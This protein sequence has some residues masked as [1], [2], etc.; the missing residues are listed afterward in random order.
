MS[1]Y[2]QLFWQSCPEPFLWKVSGEPGTRS[3]AYSWGCISRIKLIVLGLESHLACWL[4]YS[5]WQDSQAFVSW[6]RSTLAATLRIAKV[7]WVVT[8]QKEAKR[9]KFTRWYLKIQELTQRSC[10]IAQAGSPSSRF[11]CCHCDPQSGS[12][13]ESHSSK[14]E[15]QVM[16][17]CILPAEHWDIDLNGKA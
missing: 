10:P 14:F 9:D 3:W 7:P 12:C 17:F 2:C 6:K 8:L 16:L 5:L 13:Y 4:L 11:L 15:T 1:R